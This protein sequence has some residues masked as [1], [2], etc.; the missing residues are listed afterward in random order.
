MIFCLF[1]VCSLSKRAFTNQI[2]FYSFFWGGGGWGGVNGLYVFLCLF[3]CLCLY[4]KKKVPNT[5]G[6]LPERHIHFIY[7]NNNVSLPG[8]LCLP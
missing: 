1:I 3:L 4:L 2:I 7:S 6:F 5:D 8:S